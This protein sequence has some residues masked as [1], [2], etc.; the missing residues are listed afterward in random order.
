MCSAVEEQ[1]LDAGVAVLSRSVHGG[2]PAA[3]RQVRIGAVVERELHEFVARGFVLAFTRRRCVDR[4]R[5][6][7]LVARELIRICTALE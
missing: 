6:D 7:V 3:L 4:R 1:L 5:L 2:E